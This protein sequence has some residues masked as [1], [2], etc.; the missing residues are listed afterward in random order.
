M[1]DDIYIQDIKKTISIGTVLD[2][3]NAFF[4][5]AAVLSG[6]ID[7]QSGRMA[8]G[9][10]IGQAVATS[11][12]KIDTDYILNNIFDFGGNIKP[13]MVGGKIQLNY[14]PQTK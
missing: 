11:T 13:T 14:V 7:Y 4:P 3:N 10:V 5:I 6:T 1:I 8:L 2:I 9:D 12:N